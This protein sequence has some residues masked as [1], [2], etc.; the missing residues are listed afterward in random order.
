MLQDSSI[1]PLFKVFMSSTVPWRVGKV[2]ES[3][4]IGQG[5]E[6]EKFE[7]N[8]K[9]YFQNSNI[10]TF[11][12]ATSALHLLYHL[13]KKKEDLTIVNP[14]GTPEKTF[15]PGL[16]SEDQVIT[17]ALTCT[18]TNWPILANNLQ[19]KWAD[20]NPRTLN[21]SSESIINNLNERTKIISIV[22]WGGYAFD[23]DSLLD[24]LERFEKEY[25][26]RPIIISDCAHSFGTLYKNEPISNYPGVISVYSLQAIK[27]IT[28]IDG[29]FWVN[30][31]FNLN[32]RGKLTRWYGI[33]REQPRE[34]FRCEQNIEEWGFKFHMNDVCAAAGDE[35]LLH[36]EE[37]LARNRR[38]AE[39]YDNTLKDIN[40]VTL[41]QRNPK[42]KSSFWLYTMLVERRNDFMKAMT[43]R[44]ITV[45][46]VHERND[47]HTCVSQFKSELPALDFV[48]SSM[49][50]IP[51]GWWMTEDL[52]ERV[53]KSIKLGW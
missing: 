5:P 2:L 31:F 39:V 24:P 45:S 29:G 35:N 47:I 1:I 22:N 28:S 43:S 36:A 26:F 27:H 21:I 53:I 44:G 49:I 30:P 12:S 16:T 41:L 8:L 38:C 18:A 32:K 48:T 34:D 50:C 6:V 33:D 51:C 20:V 19:I 3:G 37:V 15:W 46:R 23:F 9:K 14:W 11:N 25:G 13:L 7:G 42:V 10:L 52:L 17:T 40:G 4:Y